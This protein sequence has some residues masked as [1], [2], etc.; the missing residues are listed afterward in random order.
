MQDDGLIAS[1]DGHVVAHQDR[2]HFKAFAQNGSDFPPAPLP[3]S[4]RQSETR[5]PQGHHEKNQVVR[6]MTVRNAVLA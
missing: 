3:Q 1:R 4:L 6:S 5:Q 2:P